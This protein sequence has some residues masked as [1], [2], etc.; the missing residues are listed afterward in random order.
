MQYSFRNKNCKIH[1]ECKKGMILSEKQVNFLN[2]NIKTRT[3]CSILFKEQL[4]K[5]AS[6]KFKN[7]SDDDESKENTQSNIR[8]LNVKLDDQLSRECVPFGKSIAKVLS[9]LDIHTAKEVN[10]TG[11]HEEDLHHIFNFEK[12]LIPCARVLVIEGTECISQD[13]FKSISLPTLES[14]SIAK[15]TDYS[16]LF[17]ENHIEYYSNLTH[18]KVFGI[19]STVC[20]NFDKNEEFSMHSHIRKCFVNDHLDNSTIVILS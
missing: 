11:I 14:L 10:L 16:K 6:F 4:N 7:R 19:N 13:T 8:E 3:S 2:Q 17:N 5:Q 20:H 9:Q 18:L 1:I 12:K 15:C